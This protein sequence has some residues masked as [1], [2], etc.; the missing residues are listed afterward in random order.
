MG[1]GRPKVE[2]SIILKAID[3]IANGKSIHEACKTAGMSY[4]S[5]HNYVS[6]PDYLDKYARAMEKRADFI[7]S[8]IIDIADNND[9]NADVQRDKLRVDARK[10]VVSKM[11][12]KKYGDK[13]QL[14]D[15]NG[16]MQKLDSFLGA[17]EKSVDKQ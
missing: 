5:F 1:R 11:L 8:E 17:V 12:P 10:W 3:E 16:V 14:G 7:F 2:E 15:D 6:S 4:S 9:P 13:I